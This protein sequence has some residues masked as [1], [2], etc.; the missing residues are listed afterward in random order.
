MDIILAILLGGL[1]GFAL[2]LVGASNPKKLLSMLRLQDLS[3]MKIIV[4][5]IGFASVLLSLSIELGIFNISHLSIKSTNLGVIIGG[6]IF[7]IGFGSVGTCPGTCVAATGTKGFKK[8]AASVIGG[9]V[10]AFAFSMTYGWWESMGMFR[11]MNLGNLT[12]FRISDR[13]PS[14]FQ[15]G[16]WGLLAVGILFMAGAYLL[17]LTGRK[18]E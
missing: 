5:A 1:F 12:L 2:Y 6:L 17:P 16:P 8:A 14:V 4:F 13:F 11:I 9:L 15:I 18:S 3:L 7:G 10:G